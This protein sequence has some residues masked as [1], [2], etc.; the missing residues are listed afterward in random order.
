MRK[1]LILLT[2][3]G[4]AS[5]PQPRSSVQ[6]DVIAKSDLAGVWYFR[7]TVVGVPYTTGFTFIGEQGDNEME[8]IRWDI[9]ED[10]L[11]A[12][13]SYEFVKYT[14][15]GE[16]S[17]PG[18]YFGAPVAAFKIKSHFDIIRDYN[19]STGEE[20]NKVVENTERKWYERQ[21]M[22]VDWSQNLV[23]NFDFLADYDHGG[24]SAIK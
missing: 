11:T 19:A 2:I 21:F 20:Y 22:H 7:Q 3:C 8:K 24:I 6:T 16:P 14:E 5:E 4:C 18:D 17:N 1:I 12:R 13:R 15:K 9:Q 23:S 10:V